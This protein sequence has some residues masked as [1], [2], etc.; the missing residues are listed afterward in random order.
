[1]SLARR[2]EHRIAREA[3]GGVAAVAGIRVA[4][5]EAALQPDRRP[6]GH[7][8][9]KLERGKEAVDEHRGERLGRTWLGHRVR[10]GRDDA[11]ADGLTS[12]RPG[13]CQEEPAPAGR[14]A[15]RGQD[16]IE[17]AGGDECEC[18]SPGRARNEAPSGDLHD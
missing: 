11:G 3:V 15:G 4:P 7:G 17:D 18:P 2:T 8:G 16:A 14:A 6:V 1:M 5:A 10:A 9:R 12:R 13:R